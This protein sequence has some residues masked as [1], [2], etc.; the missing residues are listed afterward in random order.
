MRLVGGAS[1][2]AT[3]GAIRVVTGTSV[4]GGTSGDF[5]LRSADGNVSGT[6]VLGTGTATR[7]ATGAVYIATGDVRRDSPAN[8]NENAA[9]GNIALIVGQTDRATHGGNVTLQGGWTQGTVAGGIQLVGGDVLASQWPST[10]NVPTAK[11]GFVEIQA[12][13][14]KTK[15]VWTATGGDVRVSGGLSLSGTG[16][17]IVLVSGKSEKSAS[18]AILVASATSDATTGEIVLSTGASTNSASGDISLSTGTA[19][20]GHAGQV[21]VRS[22]FSTSGAGASIVLTSGA[23]AKQTGT[24]IYDMYIYIY[25]SMVGRFLE[26]QWTR[27]CT[28]RHSCL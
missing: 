9:A 1:S 17:K 19:V 8:T 2:T 26:C 3:G 11:G 14:A 10:N 16:G 20:N 21:R 6:I 7:G 12:G 15:D 13:S 18:G 25:I 27:N 5:T 24:T 28:I 4:A 23:S 22:G